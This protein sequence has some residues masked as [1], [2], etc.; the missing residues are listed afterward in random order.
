MRLSLLAVA[1]V[2]LAQQDLVSLI[3]SQDDLST[4]LEAVNLVPGL[5]DTLNSAE[6]ITILAPTNAAFEKLDPESQEGIAL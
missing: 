3:Q 1:S 4:L 6:N 5:A 2:A